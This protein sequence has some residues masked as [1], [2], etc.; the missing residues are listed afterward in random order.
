[1]NRILPAVLPAGVTE[2]DNQN[3][4]VTV[5]PAGIGQDLL[6]IPAGIRAIYH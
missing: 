4:T 3:G 1:M 6:P 2:T 5:S